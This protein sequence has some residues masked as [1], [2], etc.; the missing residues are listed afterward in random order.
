MICYSIYA[1]LR[2]QLPD[3]C[4]W[5]AI[6]NGLEYWWHR[7]KVTE[8]TLIYYLHGSHIAHH[9]TGVHLILHND[10][11][12]DTLNPCQHIPLNCLSLY[13]SSAIKCF[14]MMPSSASLLH[15][16]IDFFSIPWSG[17]ESGIWVYF[18][19]EILIADNVIHWNLF[20]FHLFALKL[21]FGWRTL[22]HELLFMIK[23]TSFLS[24]VDH[25]VEF[26]QILTTVIQVEVQNCKRHI[27]R[28][29]GE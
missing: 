10:I 25:S 3:T 7:V 16:I 19:S 13:Q 20:S 15:I 29:N 5:I 12:Q 1:Q 2:Y 14:K 27:E 26:N 22:V 28:I 4:A 18:K 6:F 24:Y 17:W 11:A 8:I 23:D 9:H 21:Q